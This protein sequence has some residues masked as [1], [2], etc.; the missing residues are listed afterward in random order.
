[1]KRLALILAVLTL[2]AVPAT[3][4][5]MRNPEPKIVIPSIAPLTAT[6]DVYVGGVHLMQANIVFQEQ[7]AD[8]RARVTG[9][10]YGIWYRLVPW[11]TELK[12]SGKMQ[13]DHFVPAEFYTRDVWY[14]K[15]RTTW[16]HFKKDG[17]VTTDFDPPNKDKNREE[18]TIDQ[19]RGSLDP[20][21]GLLQLL[22]HI[23]V[24]KDCDVTVPIFEGRRRFDI[25]GTDD[26]FDTLGEDDYNAFKGE[27]RT[28][29]AAFAMVAGEWKDRPPDRFWTRNGKENEREPFHIWLGKLSPELPELPVRLETGSVWGNIIMHMSAWHYATKDEVN[30]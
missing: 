10:T 18:I 15:P 11:D 1:M 28:C 16:I 6:Y 2:A 12:V 3:A 27:A 17:D 5:P 4:K 20:V 30:N 23:A 29:N 13:G 8:Y 22:A 9:H 19:R 26:G 7:G 21:T 14:H 25:T 24:Y